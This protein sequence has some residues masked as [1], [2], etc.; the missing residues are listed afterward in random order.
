MRLGV[1][2]I[3]AAANGTLPVP[4]ALSDLRGDFHMHT[5]AS[6]G[7]DTL[8][9]MVAAAAARGYEYHAISDHS[10][11]RGRGMDPADL[12]GQRAAG[13][14][15]R[16]PHAVLVGGRYPRRRHARLRR[17]GAGRTRYRDRER[18]RRL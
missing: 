1:G 3:E 9:A 5:T 17:C 4:V 11:G 15:P 18:A 14:P 8:E 13:R 12:R 10:R 7:A 16:H 2:E 6:D